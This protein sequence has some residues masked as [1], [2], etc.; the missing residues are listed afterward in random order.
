ME[1][2]TL[3]SRPR[4]PSTFSA[5]AAPSL[6]AQVQRPSPRP[7]A[8]HTRALQRPGPHRHYLHSQASLASTQDVYLNF[9]WRGLLRAREAPGS[10]GPLTTGFLRPPSLS[11][12]RC[13][14]DNNP[15]ESG[16]ARGA[17]EEG[18]DGPP[19][20]LHSNLRDQAFGK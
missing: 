9:K 17:G 5:R 19:S 13:P 16:G 15:G 7:S 12:A 8:I 18:Q 10:Q 2:G 4:S 14:R 1:E 11:E 3:P 6:F 20:S